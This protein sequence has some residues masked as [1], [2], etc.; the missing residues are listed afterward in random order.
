MRRSFR[1][2]AAALRRGE[3]AS[4][5][6][7]LVVITKTSPVTD[8]IGT[9]DKTKRGAVSRLRLACLSRAQASA[10]LGVSCDQFGVRPAPLLSWLTISHECLPY[11]QQIASSTVAVL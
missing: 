11:F 1:R 7:P 10:A 5:P 9:E 8:A 6:D 4:P 2:S 3:F